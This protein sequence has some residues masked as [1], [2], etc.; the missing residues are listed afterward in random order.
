MHCVIYKIASQYRQNEKLRRGKMAKKKKTG[1]E[2]QYEKEIKKQW[3]DRKKRNNTV[4]RK[5]VATF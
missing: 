3:E 2:N 1:F 4:S 5:F